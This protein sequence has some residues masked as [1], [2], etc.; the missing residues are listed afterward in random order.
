M[1]GQNWEVRQGRKIS[2]DGSWATAFVAHILDYSGQS[3]RTR[4]FTQRHEAE[5]WARLNYAIVV[6]AEG[7]EPEADAAVPVASVPPTTRP[8]ASVSAATF[9]SS[10][11][12]VEQIQLILDRGGLCSQADAKAMA[13]ELM[14]LR[15]AQ[16]SHPSQI[17]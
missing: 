11:L 10:A 2:A 5:Q 3:L 13:A 12:T 16:R 4:W 15:A 8:T 7:R 14:A 17:A 1:S 6:A 9:G